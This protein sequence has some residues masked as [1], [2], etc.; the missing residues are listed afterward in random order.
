MESK[1]AFRLRFLILIVL[2]SCST[3]RVINLSSCSNAEVKF[4]LGKDQSVR[5]SFV[6]E[7]L[8]LGD[9]IDHPIELRQIL[10]RYNKSCTEFN[11]ISIETKYK[12]DDVLMSFIPFISRKTITLNYVMD[13]D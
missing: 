12:W 13:D 8:V 4:F 1:V 5:Q 7:S 11:K 2:T 10:S 6:R 3:H 9:G